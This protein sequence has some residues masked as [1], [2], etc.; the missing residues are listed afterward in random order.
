MKTRSGRRILGLCLALVV[1]AG[2]A[3]APGTAVPAAPTPT[4]SQ[5]P[6][7]LPS[8]TQPTSTP[9]VT[10]PTRTATPG[11]TPDRSSGSTTATAPGPES[12]ATAQ[13]STGSAAQALVPFFAAVA[14][15]DS[16]LQAAAAA[17]NAGI[18]E[19]TVTVDRATIDLVDAAAPW[20]AA[21]AVPA[22][23]DQATEQAVLL[24]Y[25]DLVSRYG[26]LRGGDCLQLGTVPRD[27][28]NADCFVRGHD[29]K[30]RLP[31][32]VEA[33]QAAAAASTLTTPDP[34]A[35]AAA[36]VRLR[37][38]SIEKAN[39][40]CGTM[41]GLIAT[42]PLP[43]VWASEPAG[44]PAM[45]PTEGTVNG[46]RFRATYDDSAGWSVELLAC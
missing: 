44:D 37:L 36:E 18:G 32:D 29:A 4:S 5:P 28:L 31:G 38:A 15:I 3:S 13:P 22:G 2:C 6:S 34:G 43:V 27:A 26:A 16:A 46:I 1:L 14:G 20:P 25:S 21:A 30:V 40:G 8:A 24:V 19:Q 17:V 12:A 10:A 11:A 33:A 35:R 7:T 45:P 41:G 9:P 42:D 23:L 39:L